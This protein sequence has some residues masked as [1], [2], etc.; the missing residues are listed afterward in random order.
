MNVR[1]TGVQLLTAV[2]VLLFAWTLIA[3]NGRHRPSD[4]PPRPPKLFVER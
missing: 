1:R 3:A 4:P 2:F